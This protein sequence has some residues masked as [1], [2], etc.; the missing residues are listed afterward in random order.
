MEKQIEQI[1]LIETMI[2]NAKGNIGDSSVF[3]LLWGWLVFIAA[4]LNYVLLNHTSFEN[5]WIG[6]MYLMILGGIISAV[7]GYKKG[8]TKKVQTYPERALKFLWLGFVITL[9][10]VLW[11]MGIIG[12]KATYPILML[13]YGLGTFVSGGILKFKPLI[14][15]GIL[16]WIC[17]I[18]A[19]YC[20]F[21]Y[22]LL[23][24]M[25]AILFSYIIPGHMMAQSK[26]SY[27]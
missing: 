2:A 15:G 7:L 8:R 23:L 17:G 18:I 25:L 6:W 11:G 10:S 9:F 16:A 27:V 14:V 20:S 21:S 1:Q 13:M 3:Y 26:E 4:A 12:I 19:F 22:Q 24:I 5:P